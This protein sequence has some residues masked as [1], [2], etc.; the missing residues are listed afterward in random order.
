[1]EYPC[2]GERH[3]VGKGG[4]RRQERR[5]ERQ[6]REGGVGTRA[7]TAKGESDASREV[8]GGR[9]E[10][11]IPLV[12]DVSEYWAAYKGEGVD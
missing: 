10:K 3:R 4:E 9:G 8:R 6:G 12:V 2:Q 5:R 7:G 1:M 11:R